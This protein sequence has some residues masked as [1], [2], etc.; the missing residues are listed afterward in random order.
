MQT[1]VIVS[2]RMPARGIERR[3]HDI[4][5][6]WSPVWLLRCLVVIVKES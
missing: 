3:P 6:F 5:A 4:E 1:H 2:Q